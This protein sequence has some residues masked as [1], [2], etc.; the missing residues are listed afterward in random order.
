MAVVNLRSP[1]Y[2]VGLQSEGHRH[3]PC[4]VLLLL[5]PS[6]R[7]GGGE[8]ST[9]PLHWFYCPARLGVPLVFP[10]TGRPA[11]CRVSLEGTEMNRNLSN[12]FGSRRSLS[13][14]G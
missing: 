5:G 9:G 13:A 6:E 14:R 1:F 10:V 8:G 11:G 12:V 7:C 2:L 3:R 4:V